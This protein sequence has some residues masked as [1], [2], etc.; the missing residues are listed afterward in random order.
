MYKLAKIH[1][2]IISVS[3]SPE[4]ILLCVICNIMFKK[5]KHFILHG[6]FYEFIK[7]IKII[8]V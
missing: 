3:Q 7:Q 5:T 4:I 1:F 2:E 6:D 8:S